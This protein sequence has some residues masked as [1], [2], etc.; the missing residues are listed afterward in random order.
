[1][2]AIGATITNAGLR[3]F[4][5]VAAGNDVLFA[6]NSGFVAV[7]TGNNT[8]T[9]NDTKLQAESSVAGSRKAVT[10]TQ[11]TNPGEFLVS[12][13]L[14]ATDAVGVNI[15][16]VGFFA[17]GAATSAAGTGTL[18]ARAL[19]SHPNKLNTEVITLILDM[20]V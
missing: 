18:V 3:L 14:Q 4:G 10:V 2:A 8:P 17:G 16:E 11:G 15:A 9:V 7:G 19:F 6:S 1:M 20:T 13:T 5:T 12:G